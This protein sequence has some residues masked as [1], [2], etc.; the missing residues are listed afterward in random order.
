MSSTCNQ[1]DLQ[2]LGSQPIMPKNLPRSL[3]QPKL[4]RVTSHNYT[5]KESEL[6]DTI[7]LTEVSN[8]FRG[9]N[10]SRKIF[11]KWRP[12]LR[13]R[14][15]AFGRDDGVGFLS[16]LQIEGAICRLEG[17]GSGAFGSGFG[18]FLSSTS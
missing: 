8:G 2:T 1:L 4:F 14:M 18:R 5:L 15:R 16:F 13:V 7:S 3:V 17:R 6:R 11:E 12:E 9:S 10:P